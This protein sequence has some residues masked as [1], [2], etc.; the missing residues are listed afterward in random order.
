M[1]F[2]HLLFE[3]TNSGAYDGYKEGNNDSRK[4]I[5][6]GLIK[7]L[8]KTI[9]DKILDVMGPNGDGITSDNF[10][11]IRRMYKKELTMWFSRH[12]ADVK[13][14]AS[15][16]ADLTGAGV[17]RRIKNIPVFAQKSSAVEKA[18]FSKSQGFWML[19]D[20]IPASLGMIGETQTA[21]QYK[22]TIQEMGKILAAA[23]DKFGNTE[24][25][26]RA[27]TMLDFPEYKDPSKLYYSTDNDQVY[28]VEKDEYV[29]AS[30]E[31]LSRY[32][33]QGI[34]D[35]FVQKIKD[36]QYF[37][38]IKNS[39]LIKRDQINTINQTS[40]SFSTE[41]LPELKDAINKIFNEPIYDKS[42]LLTSPT[43][44]LEL[45]AQ[46][47]RLPTSTQQLILSSINTKPTV[48]SKFYELK[49]Y[50]ASKD[51]EVIGQ[52]QNYN[53]VQNK[54]AQ[55]YKEDLADR[56][57]VV[58]ADKKHQLLQSLLNQVPY[59]TTV[60]AVS[61]F[62]DK[63]N[64]MGYAQQT[65]FRHLNPNLKPTEAMRQIIDQINQ[66]QGNNSSDNTAANNPLTLISKFPKSHRSTLDQFLRNA[67]KEQLPT[68]KRIGFL[69]K[70]LS[71]PEQQQAKIVDIISKS[72]ET[73]LQ[74]INSGKI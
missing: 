54:I 17:F 45:F 68:A 11:Y 66:R 57:S 2:S 19:H 70:L 48:K 27:P 1:K 31:D 24:N 22:S 51:Y 55:Q 6:T 63:L 30:E 43:A 47:K 4:D 60:D 64:N 10:E 12:Y 18:P 62:L 74:L 37:E 71:L 15:T 32:Q 52:D 34:Y 16:L 7:D 65:L 46:V 21:A 61:Q 9:N 56:G 20:N 5:Y 41:I 23:Y 3:A 14:A 8:I 53:E 40:K 50:L 69:T 33:D 25:F 72:P 26:V 28:K 67:S 59:S 42:T 38:K 58:W 44:K 13:S 39:G 49:H 73:V 29:P 35:D 36:P